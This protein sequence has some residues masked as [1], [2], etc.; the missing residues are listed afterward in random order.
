MIAWPEPI[1]VRAT[2]SRTVVVAEVSTLAGL[3]SR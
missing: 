3:N 1:P 2:A